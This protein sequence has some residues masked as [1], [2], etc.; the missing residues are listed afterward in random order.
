MRLKP[1]RNSR[2]ALPIMHDPDG[3]SGDICDHLRENKLLPSENHTLYSLRYSFQDRLLAANA[4]DRVQT[5]LM[6]HKFQREDYGNGASME[7]KLEYL[8]KIKLKY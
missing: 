8:E 4:P 3:L 6:G 1:F 2:T 5:D 7:Q